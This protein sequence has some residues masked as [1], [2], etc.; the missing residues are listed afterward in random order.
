M[1]T[2]T[3]AHIPTTT[4]R[5]THIHAIE[6]QFRTAISTAHYTR[7]GAYID[8]AATL[9]ETWLTTEPLARAYETAQRNV[10]ALHRRRREAAA[11]SG[12]GQT[13]RRALTRAA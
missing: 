11:N 3:H 12:V 5:A 2:L 4:R 9:W 10:S 13:A 1:A 8:V 6:H 7:N